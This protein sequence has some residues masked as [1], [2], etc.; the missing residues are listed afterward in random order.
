MLNTQEDFKI[1]SIVGTKDMSFRTNK[2]R[3]DRCVSKVGESQLGR[4]RE[5]DNLKEG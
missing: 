4:K 5:E 1:Y 2:W 3:V